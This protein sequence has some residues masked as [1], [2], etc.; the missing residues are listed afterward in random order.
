MYNAQAVVLGNKVYIGGGIMD[1][2]SPSRLLVYDYTKES[3]EIL[4]TPVQWYALTTYHSQLV[5]VG[6][7]DPDTLEATNQLWVLDE[8]YRWTQPLPP[9]TIKRYQASTVI[10]GDY[11]IV[12]GG[13]GGSDDSHLDTVEVY[14]GHQWMMAQSLPRACSCMKTTLYDGNWYLASGIGQGSEVYHVSLTS[15]IPTIHFKEAK[16]CKQ[17]SVWKQLPDAPLMQFTPAVLRKQLI[18]VGGGSAIHAYSPNTKSWVHVGDLPIACDATCTLVLPTGELL[19]VGEDESG[20]SS[21]SFRP[22]T[23]GT[24]MC[25]VNSICSMPPVYLML[26]L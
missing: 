12:A 18:T 7:V 14:D 25:F 10:L 13:C 16:H 17:T 24:S 20:L 26:T 15:L 2:G 8:Q 23:R 11:L 21:H 3:W 5:L 4:N 22:S 1:P 6:G 9:M 19:V